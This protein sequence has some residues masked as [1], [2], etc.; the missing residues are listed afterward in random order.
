MREVDKAQ[1]SERLVIV[2]EMSTKQAFAG[3]Q[4]LRV[5]AGVFNEITTKVRDRP[6]YVTLDIAWEFKDDAGWSKLRYGDNGFTWRPNV[7]DA[8]VIPWS[9]EAQELFFKVS[10]GMVRLTGMLRA[11]LSQEA[12]KDGVP[13]LGAGLLALPDKPKS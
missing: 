4:C 13:K 9:E 11:I 1:K 6:D 5:Q 12:W 2:C 7:R 3:G 10:D 8:L